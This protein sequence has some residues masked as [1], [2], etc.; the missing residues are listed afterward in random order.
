MANNM[1]G[2]VLQLNISQGGLPKYAID[3]GRITEAGLDGDR[4]AHPNIH[5]G[6]RQALLLITSEGLAELSALGIPIAPG[7]LGENITTQGLDRREWRAGQQWAIGAEVV[8]EFTKMRA[9]CATLNPVGRGIQAA[10]FDVQVKAGDPASS[11]WGLS[12]FYA[13]VLTPGHVRAGDA[14]RPA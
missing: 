7:M 8:I 13:K 5:G 4:H 11:R 10:L 1:C 14:I 12:G 3:T 9:P 2:S 6:P